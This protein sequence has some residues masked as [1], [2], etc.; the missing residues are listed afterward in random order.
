[1]GLRVSVTDGEWLRVGIGLDVGVAVIVTVSHGEKPRVGVGLRVSV[2]DRDALH[3]E[4][5]DP[6]AFREPA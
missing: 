3:F 2:V 6:V 5:G 1:M 4:L